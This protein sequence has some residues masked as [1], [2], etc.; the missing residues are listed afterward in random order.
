MHEDLKEQHKKEVEE[1]EV[2]NKKVLFTDHSTLLQYYADD[3]KN[4]GRSGQDDVLCTPFYISSCKPAT[5]F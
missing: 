4:R 3:R 2:T 5:N 1:L